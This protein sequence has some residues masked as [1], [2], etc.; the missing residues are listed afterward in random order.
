MSED[1]F[2]TKSIDNP[3]V[4][5]ITPV[6]NGIKY[7]ETCIQSVLSQSYPYI[8]HIIVDGASTDGTVEMLRSYQAKYPARI[9]FI[10]EPDKSPEEAWNKGWKIAKGGIFGWLGLDEAYE[11]DAIEKVV[12]F[13]KANQGAYFVFG[14]GN[15]VDETGRKIC[16]SYPTEDFELKR[17]INDRC[18]ACLGA[19]TAFYKREVIE[20]VG[21]IDTSTRASE[22]DF[23]IRVGKEFTIHRI[24]KLLVN[25]KVYKG[26]FSG[27][28]EAFKMSARDGFI[29]SRRYG[30]GRFS[31]RAKRYYR[32]IILD[33]LHLFYLLEYKLYPTVLRKLLRRG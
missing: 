27:S 33:K 20:K 6:L 7:L 19:P 26:R 13:F 24:D 17:V 1:A 30:G 29:I 15:R 9:R 5:I 31:R 22:L 18:P 12:K 11:L 2:P 21:L 32:F 3:L 28:F 25:I 16:S 4:S 23:W 10:S 14:G 8:E